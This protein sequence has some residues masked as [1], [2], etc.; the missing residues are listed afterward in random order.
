MAQMSSQGDRIDPSNNGISFVYNDVIVSG[1]KQLLSQAVIDVDNDINEQVSKFR[2]TNSMER[3]DHNKK[4]QQLS[5]FDNSSKNFVVLYYQHKRYLLLVNMTRCDKYQTYSHRFISHNNMWSQNDITICHCL[6]RSNISCIR[7]SFSS[8]D[9]FG[10]NHYYST[11]CLIHQQTTPIYCP[12][13]HFVLDNIFTH[14]SQGVIERAQSNPVSDRNVLV[15][16]DTIP[17]SKPPT[18]T[19]SRL[20]HYGCILDA[21]SQFIPHLSQESKLYTLLTNLGLLMDMEK[22]DNDGD[23]HNDQNV[24]NCLG[25]VNDISPFALTY[26]QRQIVSKYL[27]QPVLMNKFLARKGQE[28]PQT[29]NIRTIGSATPPSTP[30]VDSNVREV[31]QS[32]FIGADLLGKHHQ[33][34]DPPTTPNRNINNNNSNFVL[35]SPQMKQITSTIIHNDVIPSDDLFSLNSTNDCVGSSED[36]KPTHHNQQIS[37]AHTMN[38]QRF[39]PPQIPTSPSLMMEFIT[40][41][42]PRDGETEHLNGHNPFSG[43]F[44]QESIHIY[45]SP[46]LPLQNQKDL[47]QFD[48]KYTIFHPNPIETQTPSAN[49]QSQDGPNQHNTSNLHNPRSNHSMLAPKIIP[50]DPKIAFESKSTSQ[51][52]N[53]H[54]LHECQRFKHFFQNDLHSNSSMFN[55]VGHPT[56][57]KSGNDIPTKSDTPLCSHVLASSNSIKAIINLSSYHSV[58]DMI[59]IITQ[60][61]LVSIHGAVLNH[62][63][64]IDTI[65]NNKNCEESLMKSHPAKVNK[66]KILITPTYYLWCPI[67]DYSP[68]SLG[69]ILFICLSFDQVVQLNQATPNVLKNAN[70]VSPTALLTHCIAGQGR[71]GCINAVYIIYKYY[72]F[73]FKNYLTSIGQNQPLFPQINSAHNVGSNDS[74]DIGNGDHEYLRYREYLLHTISSLP[75]TTPL[76]RFSRSNASCVALPQHL[77][78]HEVINF[79]RETRPGSIETQTQESI[80]MEFEIE[81]R[82]LLFCPRKVTK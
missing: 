30:H 81:F 2:K 15:P 12:K 14:V 52:F 26:H 18:L 46:S 35:K 8:T 60:S 41:L 24:N 78:S 56:I 45:Q 13:C 66:N 69:Q 67:K 36:H 27:S 19:R 62:C 5:I 9:G 53:I 28:F 47:S 70:S 11:P 6:Y 7:L 1:T 79:I 75:I 65:H 37:P 25:G 74:G 20:F 38:S 51:R 64:N 42:S 59:D 44:H 31:F 80:V 43:I 50:N 54:F 32:E 29:P 55:H 34:F 61:L 4:T 17:A 21:T 68:P 33:P 40:D 71:T 39:H 48:H 58:Y 63:I 77:I 82:N 10:T 22:E 57:A 73:F 72:Q 76:E 3:I 16:Y 49:I 23:V